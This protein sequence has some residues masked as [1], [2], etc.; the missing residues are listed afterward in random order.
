MTAVAALIGTGAGLVVHDYA[1]DQLIFVTAGGFI[2]LACVT[3][4]PDVLDESTTN[5]K[6]PNSNGFRVAVVVAFGLGIAFLYVVSLLEELDESGH[7]HSHSHHSHGHDHH[8]T[9]K[10][11]RYDHHHSHHDIAHDHAVDHDHH[12]HD[13]HHHDHV[14]GEL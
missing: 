8:V 12:D 5:R 1:G 9:D 2:Y 3:I 6:R 14:N 4:L 10:E 7:V 13:Y 11:S